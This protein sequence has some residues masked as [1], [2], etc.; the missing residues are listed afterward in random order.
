MNSIFDSRRAANIRG[1]INFHGFG[2]FDTVDGYPMPKVISAFILL[3]IGCSDRLFGFYCVSW[4]SG[5]LR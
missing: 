4:S 1:R 2:F 5:E 3:D